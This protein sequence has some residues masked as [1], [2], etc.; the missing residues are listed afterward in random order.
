MRTYESPVR[1]RWLRRLGAAV[2]VS[3]AAVTAPVITAAPAAAVSQTAIHPEWVDGCD[4][5]PGP[6]FYVQAVLDQRIKYAVTKSVADGLSGL[7]AA[8]RTQD[9][10]A[11]KRLHDVAIRTMSDGA[12]Q[13]GNAAWVPGEWDGDLCPKRDW[14]F[15]GPKPHWDETQRTLADGLSLLAQYNRTGDGRLLT[16]ADGKLTTGADALLDFQGCV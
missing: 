8:S 7:I 4:G 10:V 3:I 13:A 14:P 12:A 6:L 9:P 11:A 15:P 16:A 2:A 1:G 5:C